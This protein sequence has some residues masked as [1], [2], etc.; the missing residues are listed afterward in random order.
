MKICTT[1][2]TDRSDLELAKV[3][4]MAKGDTLDDLV[5]AISDEIA[6][7]LAMAQSLGKSVRV[8]DGDGNELDNSVFAVAEAIAGGADCII[9]TH[10]L[11][12]GESYENVFTINDLGD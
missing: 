5:P 10:T 6:T 8:T 1:Y 3:V 2:S 4:I 11:P 9:L 7:E 12:D